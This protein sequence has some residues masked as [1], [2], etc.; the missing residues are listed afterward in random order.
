MTIGVRGKFYM[1]IQKK[2]L[3][4]LALAVAVPGMTA[5]ALAGFAAAPAM[6]STDQPH[7]HYP[8]YERVSGFSNT[9]ANSINVQVTGGFFD[10]GTASL[11]F[12]GG[13]TTTVSLSQGTQTMALLVNPSDITFNLHP[14]T[15]SGTV[16]LNAPLEVTSG[17]GAYAGLTGPGTATLTGNISVPRQFN[18]GCN[19]NIAN[20]MSLAVHL[21]LVATASLSPST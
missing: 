16:R 17:T 10:H 6:A 2:A 8:V 12:N 19:L 18:G 9:L 1:G 3:R 5:G 14:G 15:C 4:R 7:A 21:S 13:L 20:P 11:G